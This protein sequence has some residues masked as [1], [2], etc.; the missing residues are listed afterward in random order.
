MIPL[1][2]E[3]LL[4]LKKIESIKKAREHYVKNKD[5]QKEYRLNNKERYKEYER[6][7]QIREAIRYGRK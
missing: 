4:F 7:Y 5:R 2:N 1:T 3:R 6:Q